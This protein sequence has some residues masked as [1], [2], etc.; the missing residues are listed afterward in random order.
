MGQRELPA[1]FRASAAEA[2]FR[3]PGR[4]DL[5]LIVSD[6]PAVLAGL[7]TQNA[8]KAAPVIVCQEILARFGTARAVLANSGQANACTGEEG[9]ANCRRTQAMAAELLGLTPSDVLPISTGVIGAQLP[10]DRFGAALPALCG[11]LGGAD[12]EGFTRAFMTTDAF[13][14][15]SSRRVEL[16]GG[17]V[18]LTV[19]AKGAGMICPNMATM[20]AVALTDAAADRALWQGMFA[21]AVSLTFNRVS[22]DGD[23][24][25]N[26]TILGLANGA[27]GVAAVSAGDREALERELTEVLGAV[28]HMLVKDGEGARKVIHV[29]VTGAA[30]DR[31]A[32]VVARSV[33]GSQLVKTA[34]YG[35]D[36][37]WGRIV[38]AVGYS[39]VIFDPARV[40]LT[41]CGIDRFLKGRPVNDDKEEQLAEL[42]RKDDVAVDIALGD[43]PGS[44]TL[45]TSD[46]GH[47]YV[48]LNADYR[49]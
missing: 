42:L 19:M 1:G 10:M 46:L 23:T 17:C 41:L 27:S 29:A 37:N 36:A 21:R 14:K 7:F 22:V 45:Q 16:S 9:M 35:G 28:A 6:R 8:F 38:T 33:G 12:A 20:L 44:Y 40:R 32:E 18:R 25:T 47:E 3:K 15:Y 26:D 13:P 24:S 43:G 11:N 34:I 39:G 49:S 31:D 4:N 5:G 48:S 2:G 30:S